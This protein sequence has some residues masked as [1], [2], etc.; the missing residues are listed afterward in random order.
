MTR[1]PE[2]P[3]WWEWE[4]DLGLDHLREQMIRRGFGELEL[5]EMLEFATGFREDEEFGRWLV[6]TA[7]D[8]QPWAVI[9]EPQVSDRILLVIT[10]YRV[11][12]L[13]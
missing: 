5:R 9:V 6:E 4:L 7:Y 3:E 2:W 12:P 10:A 8:H 11:E 13:I 1:R